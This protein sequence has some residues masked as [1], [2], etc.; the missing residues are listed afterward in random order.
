MY[1]AVT[2]FEGDL[3][4]GNGSAGHFTFP[5]VSWS[6]RLPAVILTYSNS[7]CGNHYVRASTFTDADLTA[8]LDWD[9]AHQPFQTS[10][11]ILPGTFI[12]NVNCIV[13]SAMNDAFTITSMIV[14]DMPVTVERA[15]KVG[16]QIHA[17]VN[18][19]TIQVPLNATPY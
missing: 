16:L 6:L 13:S 3:T 8:V 10:V 4:I 12:T 17:Q 14:M 11:A 5:L 9:E 15:G 18:G 19:G 7:L 1:T 2:G